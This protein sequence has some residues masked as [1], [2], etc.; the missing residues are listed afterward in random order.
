M[1]SQLLYW[2]PLTCFLFKDMDLLV[3]SFKTNFLASS[4]SQI[5]HFSAIF[6]TSIVFFFLGFFYLSPSS[7]PFLLFYFSLSL[8]SFLLST[9]TILTSPILV[10][11]TYYT[12]LDTLSSLFLLFSSQ[13]QN[14]S[15]LAI[16]F[17]RSH[18]TPDLQLH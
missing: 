10:S 7:T 3:E 4:S 1:I 5:S 2:H 16:V 6:F 15:R 18:S 8:F 17:P 12:S 9:S 14:Y 13:Y 11:T